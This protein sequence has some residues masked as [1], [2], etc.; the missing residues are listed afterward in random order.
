MT[1][2][3]KHMQG[4]QVHTISGTRLG[5]VA[6]FDLDAD[7]GRLAAVRVK[8]SRMVPAGLGPEALVA[9]SQI[10]SMDDKEVVVVDAFVVERESWMKKSFAHELRS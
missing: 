2:N 7:T 3:S 8:I 9:W 4:V 6:S 10:V 1:V 5:Q